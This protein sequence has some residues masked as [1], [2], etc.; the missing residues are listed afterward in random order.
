[1]NDP[2]NDESPRK[3]KKWDFDVTKCLVCSQPV[4]DKTSSSS[5]E[6]L[7][8]IYGYVKERIEYGDASVKDFWENI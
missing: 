1:M 5:L 2:P 3:R 7:Q 4:G 6:V 8:K